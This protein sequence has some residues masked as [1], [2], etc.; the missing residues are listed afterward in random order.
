MRNLSKALTAGAFAGTL[1]LGLLGGAALANRDGGAAAPYELAAA[2][3]VAA[4]AASLAGT[5]VAFLTDGG[6]KPDRPRLR[7]G[8]RRA[9]IGVH[10]ETT[11]RARGGGFETYAWQRGEVTAASGTALTVKSADGVSWTWTVTGDSKV[12]KNGD[13]STPTALAA[14]DDVF[15]LG[16]PSGDARTALGVVVPKR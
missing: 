14:G 2:D 11:V 5:P 8:A 1:T 12:R 3:P 9:L 10:G 6:D 4:E 16:R 13:K 7:L 15:V